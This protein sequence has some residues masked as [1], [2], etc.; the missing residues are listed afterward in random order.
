MNLTSLYKFL[1]QAISCNG[2]CGG[3]VHSMGLTPL[4]LDLLRIRCVELA[5]L[6]TR[7]LQE[8]QLVSA[9]PAEA[10]LEGTP[11]TKFVIPSHALFSGIF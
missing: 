8:K 4:F 9:P 10:C 11:M 2:S 1:N 7:F 3:G 6:F 5:L